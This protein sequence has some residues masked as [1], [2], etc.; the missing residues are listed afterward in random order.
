MCTACRLPGAVDRPSDLWQTLLDKRA[1]NS[2]KVPKSRFN[3][4]A[5]LHPDEDRP[6]SIEIPGGYYLDG[7]AENF[8][9]TFFH[10]T[11][12]EG[13]RDRQKLVVQGAGS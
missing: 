10:M 6:G 12:V 13:L 3:I 2:D 9:P 8:D 7:N 1:G 11:P 4:D 5:F